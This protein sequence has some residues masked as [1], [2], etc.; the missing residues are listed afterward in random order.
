MASVDAVFMDCSFSG[1][2]DN[3]RNQ[4]NGVLFA[5]TQDAGNLHSAE[6]IKFL[7]A[8]FN[9]EPEAK[10]HFKKT[11][12]RYNSAAQSTTNEPLVALLEYSADTW[13]TPARPHFKIS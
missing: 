11:V 1:S 10:H 8:F 9:L 12:E 13:S 5:S 6:Y 3:V 4:T 2:C 7:A